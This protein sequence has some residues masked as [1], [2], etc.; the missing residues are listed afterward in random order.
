MNKIF[1]LDYDW[2]DKNK[3]NWIIGSNQKKTEIKI[4]KD[5]FK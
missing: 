4:R 2:I 1:Q 5:E 3:N